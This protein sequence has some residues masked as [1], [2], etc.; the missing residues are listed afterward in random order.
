MSALRR[1]VRDQAEALG[2][3]L[4]PFEEYKAAFQPGKWTSY[5]KSCGAMCIV[6]EEYWQ[7]PGDQVSGKVLE[8]SCSEPTN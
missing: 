7:S 6:Y 4:T 8:A 5:C 3:K 2:H 1:A